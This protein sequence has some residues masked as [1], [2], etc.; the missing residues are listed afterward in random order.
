LVAI[1]KRPVNKQEITE[2]VDAITAE[3]IDKGE[4]RAKYIGERALTLLHKLDDVAYVRFL[5]VYRDFGTLAQFRDEIAR[6]TPSLRVHKKGGRVEPFDRSKLREGLLR[7]TS[8]RRVPFERLEDIVEEIASRPW[9]SS[10]V[11]S[12]EIGQHALESLSA[13][14]EVAY[15]RF[16]SVYR[17]FNSVDDFLAALTELKA[18]P[19]T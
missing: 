17:N 5:S 2:F 11:S 14:D 13:L 6:L 10:V 18:G 3:V 9:P 19:D 15:I 8:G 16:A 1:N 12:S 7:A 4:I